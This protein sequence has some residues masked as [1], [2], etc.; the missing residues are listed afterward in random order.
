MSDKKNHF[1]QS[2]C[3][4][5]TFYIYKEEVISHEKIISNIKKHLQQGLSPEGVAP[6]SG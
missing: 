3:N 1:M 4:F 5:K 2:K 6:D